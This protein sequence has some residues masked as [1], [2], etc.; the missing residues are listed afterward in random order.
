MYLYLTIYLQIIE[1]QNFKNKIWVHPATK[2]QPNPKQNAQ[3]KE[4]YFERL[5]KL[6]RGHET[7][8]GNRGQV[9]LVFF[10]C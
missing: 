9:S 1:F 10:H 8:V 4:R 2:R 7:E 5:Q 3:S 6:L